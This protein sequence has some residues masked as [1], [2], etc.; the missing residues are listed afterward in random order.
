MVNKKN[1]F[2]IWWIVVITVFLFMSWSIIWAMNNRLDDV[3]S[4]TNRVEEVCSTAFPNL[5]Q[6]SGGGKFE[7]SQYV[8]KTNLLI[9][10]PDKIVQSIR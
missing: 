9:L 5:E 1:D 8:N 4:K 3:I 7:C 2:G 6:I 10:A